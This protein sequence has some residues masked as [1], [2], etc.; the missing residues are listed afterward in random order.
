MA[1]KLYGGF[2]YGLGSSNAARRVDV[3]SDTLRVTLHTSSYVPNQ[4]THAF[5]SDLTNELPTANGYAGPVNL[6]SKTW[7]LDANQNGPV[8]DAADLAWPGASWAAHRFAVVHKSTGSAA[9]SPLI[10][11]YDLGSDAVPG[12]ATYNLTWNASGIF[13]LGAQ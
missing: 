1:A 8:F 7:V 9:T 5:Y 13:V 3:L 2:L 10:F 6:T 4:D 11:Y 12:G